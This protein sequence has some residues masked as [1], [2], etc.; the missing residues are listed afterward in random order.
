[1]RATVATRSVLIGLLILL[2]GCVAPSEIEDDLQPATRTVASIYEIDEFQER[3][4]A[5]RFLEAVNVVRSKEG[6]PELEYSAELN[7]A[8]FTHALDMSVQKRPW[9]FGS[10][11][12]SP[13]SRARR[14]GFEGKLIGENISESFDTPLETL[15]RWLEQENT[16]SIILSADA[17]RVGLGWRQDPD[18]RI[19]WVM[20][21]AG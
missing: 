2:T 5:S 6:L 11:R 9:H 14:A 8:S 1:L 17:K 21:V 7:G 16:R 13:V 3:V 19:W 4:L 12:S 18:G 15:G 10:D 20:L